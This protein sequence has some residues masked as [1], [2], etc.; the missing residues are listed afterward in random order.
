MGAPIVGAVVAANAQAV[1]SAGSG[2]VK[3]RRNLGAELCVKRRVTVAQVENIRRQHVTNHLPPKCQRPAALRQIRS[4][5]RA[6]CRERLVAVRRLPCAGTRQRLRHY[7]RAV[8]AV[9]IRQGRRA[10]ACVRRGDDFRPTVTGH[11]QRINLRLAYP[12]ALPC[13]WRARCDCN[14][15]RYSWHGRLG[16]RRR[17][18]GC[19]RL[20]CG[21]LHGCGGCRCRGG[22]LRYGFHLDNA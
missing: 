12:N 19:G 14:L 2:V 4:R 20:G 15:W 8:V 6:E 16:C 17:R 10:R 5:H 9:L 22:R 21:R 11:G 3:P 1:R 7:R 18:S 13:A